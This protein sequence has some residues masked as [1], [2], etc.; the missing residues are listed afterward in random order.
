MDERR[1]WSIKMDGPGPLIIRAP[2]TPPIHHAGG[3]TLAQVFCTLVQARDLVSW[4][5]EQGV[6][7]E[8]V[9]EPEVSSDLPLALPPP[10][11]VPL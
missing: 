2:G 11:E 8:I 9:N 7:G 5:Q 10:S 4:L 6:R 1:V 3:H